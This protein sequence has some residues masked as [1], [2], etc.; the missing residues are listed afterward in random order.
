MDKT[1]QSLPRPGF[2]T[3]LVSFHH[4]LTILTCS[5]YPPPRPQDSDPY[6]I[7]RLSARD[8]KHASD[9]EETFSPDLQGR[10]QYLFRSR[11]FLGWLNGPS[12]SI[13]LVD[14][15]IEGSTDLNI[16]VTSVFAANFSKSILS[17]LPEQAVVVHF[18]CGPHSYIRDEYHGPTGMVLFLVAQLA[19]Q[20]H[21][22]DPEMA[23]WDLNFID[24]PERLARLGQHDLAELCRTFHALVDR[25]P[26]GMTVYCV[27]D[28]VGFM[29]RDRM[30]PD[31]EFVMQCLDRVVNDEGLRATVKVLM[32]NQSG[33][34]YR[35]KR[36]PAFEGN[37]LDLAPGDCLAVT[38]SRKEIE[39]QP[40]QALGEQASPPHE[41]PNFGRGTSETGT[42][43]T[44]TCRN[45]GGTALASPTAASAGKDTKY[46]NER[47][48]TTAVASKDTRGTHTEAN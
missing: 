32:F 39:K 30:W 33:S 35:M 26:Q 40:R 47:G 3:T 13:L 44:E 41:P 45:A 24:H 22:M 12:H 6:A 46:I 28:S 16:S 5:S 4:F 14:A 29:D 23:S 7:D 38:I 10:V 17:V 31:F 34:T 37:R 9:E 27:I 25:V 36:V 43:D 48:T 21:D 1:A 8:L 18:F 15:N 19:L 20:L 2:S 11:R 42:T